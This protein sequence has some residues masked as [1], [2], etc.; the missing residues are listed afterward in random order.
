MKNK[1]LKLLSLSL[2]LGGWQQGNAQTVV[3]KTERI[4]DI[5][6]GTT[7]GSKPQNFFVIGSQIFF[8][9]VNSNGR[10][11]WKTD[12]TAA[13]TM[14]LKDIYPGADN[15]DPANFQFYGGLVYFTAAATNSVRTIWRT[16]GTPTGTIQVSTAP[17]VDGMFPYNGIMLFGG[18]GTNGMELWKT[19][20]FSSGTTEIKDLYT[21]IIP[22]G[23]HSFAHLGTNVIFSA[24]PTGAGTSTLWKT[25]GTAV[26]TTEIAQVFVY[27]YATN[28]YNVTGRQGDD[29]FEIGGELYFPGA[30]GTVSDFELWKTDG[31][32]AGT[33]LVKDIVPGISAST[34]YGLRVYNGKL[35]FGVH[36]NDTAYN[37]FYVS[38]GT[39][40]GTIRLKSQI[41]LGKNSVPEYA[42]VNGKLFF[43]ADDKI[44]VTD[45]TT[46]GT[47]VLA[48]SPDTAHGLTVMKGKLF[49]FGS[50]ATTPNMY[51]LIC[52]EDENT[53]YPV[54]EPFSKKVLPY[55]QTDT[56]GKSIYFG[57]STE[58][59]RN[60]IELWR[61]TDTN[62]LSV[63]N[64]LRELA[65]N[66]YPNPTTGSFSVK[67]ISGKH[68][69]VYVYSLSGQL[70]LQSAKTENIDIAQLPAGIYTIQVISDGV[71]SVGKLRKQ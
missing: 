66:I 5:N 67:N 62:R 69:T 47:H 71:V 34:P 39:S 68:T 59:D 45:G 36:T 38:D 2:L 55:L 27:P 1:L 22:S 30:A 43:T 57:M 9:A 15:S 33:V 6:T 65:S 11:L 25:D 42:Q 26:G 21:G 28:Y 41:E 16:D 37:G 20:G 60:D 23:P 29:M 54:S 12:G 44:W 64:V 32:T 10:E 40:S 46:G 70:L 24:H 35:Y 31:T 51:T 53:I 14:M 58:P 7:A 19:N 63:Q 49:C 18:V 13:N 50:T 56:L 61:F 17:I 3:G 52:V 8:S 4:Y 48:N